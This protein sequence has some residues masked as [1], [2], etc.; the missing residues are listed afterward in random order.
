M[1]K[2]EEIETTCEDKEETPVCT[3]LHLIRNYVRKHKLAMFTTVAAT[4]VAIV[5][6]KS[7]RNLRD[8]LD[9]LE[10]E[11][12]EADAYPELDAPSNIEDAIV[13][14]NEEIVA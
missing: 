4:A 9:D 12:L 13:I 11:Q 14:D 5:S 10:A 6:I 7:N 2:T 8:E 3:R 1:K